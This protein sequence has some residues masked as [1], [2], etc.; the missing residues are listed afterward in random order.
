MEINA[1]DKKLFTDIYLHYCPL[2]KKIAYDICG[3]YSVVEDLVN[4]AFIKIYGKIPIIK[5]LKDCQRTLYLISTMKNVSLNYVR[6]RSI[7]SNKV[8]LGFSDDYVA[9]IPEKGLSIEDLYS[10]KEMI[11]ELISG[12]SSLS[13]KDQKLL[14]L[15]YYYELSAREIGNI[16]EIPVNNVREYIVR[17]RHRA[18]KV[19]EKC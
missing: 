6:H 17:A 1:V 15:K 18:K 9:S 7:S 14:Y 11:N 2:M 3:E 16:M 10:I 4:E 12:K 5:S 8:L 19:I 13:E